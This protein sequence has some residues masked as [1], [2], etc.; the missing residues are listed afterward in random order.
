MIKI[1]VKTIFSIKYKIQN[2]IQLLNIYNTSK[3]N[4]IKYNQKGQKNYK[5]IIKIINN[6][7]YNVD[8]LIF[9]PYLIQE[10]KALKTQI[11]LKYKISNNNLFYHKHL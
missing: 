5:I 6:P 3:V 10:I 8:I 4:I 2:L 9:C 7:Y 1:K 11:Q